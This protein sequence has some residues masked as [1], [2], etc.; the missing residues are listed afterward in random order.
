MSEAVYIYVYTQNQNEWGCVLYVYIQNEM[1]AYIPN[2]NEC[3]SV[4]IFVYTQ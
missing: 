2:E 3:G 4:N 1:H